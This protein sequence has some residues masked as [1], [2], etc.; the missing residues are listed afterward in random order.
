MSRPVC[1]DSYALIT[2][3]GLRS[4]AGRVPWDADQQGPEDVRRA[5]VLQRIHPGFGKLALADRLAFAAAS[6]MLSACEAPPDE[7][8]GI[9]IALPFGSL[10]TDLRYNES[11]AAGP[12]SPALFSATLPSSTV[13]D[14]AIIHKLK[15]PNR[16]FAHGGV[17]GLYA[18]ESAVHL[19]ERGL[20]D[21]MLVLW[22]AALEEQDRESPHVPLSQRAI[23]NEAHAV[24]LRAAPGQLL[25]M[26]CSFALEPCRGG[27]SSGDGTDYFRLF[28]NAV[29]QGRSEVI[30]VRTA[31]CTGRIELTRG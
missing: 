5:Q 13:S 4:P 9:C 16:V 28:A 15:G 27:V 8:T 31:D 19:I 3:D 7:H 2:A 10:S 17:S 12:P 22:V 11:V 6:L 14:I 18:L 26:R 23:P 30:E 29:A 21:T 20:T 25:D 24:L 1:V